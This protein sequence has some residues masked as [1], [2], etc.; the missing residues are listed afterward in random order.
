MGNRS[1]STLI[2]IDGRTFKDYKKMI[3]KSP[4]CYMQIDSSGDIVDVNRS[5][6]KLFKARSRKKFNK[7][8]LNEITPKVQP[9]LKQE[10]E[11][12]IVNKII[13]TLERA[14]QGKG[15]EFVW[16]YK[17]CEDQELWVHIRLRAINLVGSFVIEGLLKPIDNPEEV[18]K[19]LSKMK[20][21][22]NEQKNNKKQSKSDSESSEE[23]E[24]EDSESLDNEGNYSDKMNEISDRMLNL[25]DSDNLSQIFETLSKIKFLVRDAENI[26]LE[27][28]VV[29]KLNGIDNFFN[30]VLDNRNHHIYHLGERL[31]NERSENRKKYKQLEEHL[32]RRL[33][34]MDYENEKKREIEISN[35]NLTENIKKWQEL[36]S[37][38]ISL[39][40]SIKKK[41]KKLNKDKNTDQENAEDTSTSISISDSDGF[42]ILNYSNNSLSS[43]S[44]SSPSPSSSS[45]K[46]QIHPNSNSK[47][48]SEDN[49]DSNSNSQLKLQLESDLDSI[50]KTKTD[51]II[52]NT[53][54]NNIET[55]NSKN[56][57][58]EN[59]K[60]KKKNN[61]NF[62]NEKFM[63]EKK[64]LKKSNVKKK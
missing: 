43:S 11:K 1:N 39:Q 21:S 13:Q 2:K 14:K 64:K 62:E 49:S 44:Y 56:E 36:L 45:D 41:K 28:L 53:Q 18:H 5:T 16:L 19:K 12:A 47:T 10:T 30:E 31:M 27:K 32:Q 57:N 22:G 40:K 50:T 38:Q 58:I 46:S 15:N 35:E 29:D 4:D 6:V 17:D 55:N 51:K 3:K 34:G 8:K 61:K 37:A 23:E 26:E 25:Q 24:S 60:E 59:L 52:N 33:G 7:F 54:S 9:H 20:N 63:K 42:D 48:N